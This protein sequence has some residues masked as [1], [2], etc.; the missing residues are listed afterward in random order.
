MKDGL[1]TLGEYMSEE[2][3]E[4]HAD[5]FVSLVT[6]S[7]NAD[8]VRVRI[9][10]KHGEFHPRIELIVPDSVL[11]GLVATAAE[12]ARQRRVPVVHLWQTELVVT[13]VVQP[14]T[15]DLAS[16]F[17]PRPS[18]E[19]IARLNT[20]SLLYA[21]TEKLSIERKSLDRFLRLFCLTKYFALAIL[22]SELGAEPLWEQPLKTF[23][24]RKPP[25]LHR[26]PHRT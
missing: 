17:F 8:S 10:E 3:Y 4:G 11:P 16:Q 19:S 20:N 25:Q 9:G 18:D 2:H 12:S 15:V 13:F 24:P 22:S 7:A 6:Y 23:N 1:F 14:Y 5:K 26:V 21:S